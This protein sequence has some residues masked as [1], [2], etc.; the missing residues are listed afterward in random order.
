MLLLIPQPLPSLQNQ[1]LSPIFSILP[2]LVAANSCIAVLISS[3]F[4]DYMQIHYSVAHATQSFV[5]LSIVVTNGRYLISPRL[6]VFIIS[7]LSMSQGTS[8]LYSSSRYLTA[9]MGCL[10]KYSEGT[11]S[12]STRRGAFVSRKGLGSFQ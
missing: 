12:A 9:S 6:W 3:S 4:L 11:S 10:T 8:G 7:M 1:P 2:H 5:I